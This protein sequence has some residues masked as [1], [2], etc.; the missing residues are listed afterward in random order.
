[1]VYVILILYTVYLDS[2]IFDVQATGNLVEVE[3]FC[4]LSGWG[5]VEG[6]FSFSHRSYGNVRENMHMSALFSRF[7]Q[8]RQKLSPT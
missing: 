2:D 8:K 5:R 1:M 4:N 3:T 6:I 7:E